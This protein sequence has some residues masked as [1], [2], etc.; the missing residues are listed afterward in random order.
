M[1]P[2]NPLLQAE[3]YL[4]NRE[5]RQL[6]DAARRQFRALAL[7]FTVAKIHFD[8]ATHSDKIN[9]TC[10]AYIPNYGLLANTKMINNLHKSHG[11][12]AAQGS[13]FNSSG[14][15]GKYSFEEDIRILED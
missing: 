4:L 6:P 8:T 12:L 13:L 3:S 10:A 9:I 14:H 2:F 7:K 11:V 5:E 1:S 15:W